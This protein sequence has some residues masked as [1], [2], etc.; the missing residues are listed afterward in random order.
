VGE[1][2]GSLGA[3]VGLREAEVDLGRLLGISMLKL[4]LQLHYFRLARAVFRFEDCRMPR[5]GYT[6]LKV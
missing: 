1:T 4:A 3:A 2:E 5:M 6:D